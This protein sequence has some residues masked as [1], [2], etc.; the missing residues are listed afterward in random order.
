MYT[1]AKGKTYTLTIHAVIDLLDRADVVANQE[2]VLVG[3]DIVDEID[4]R[5]DAATL[6]GGE[7]GCVADHGELIKPQ[8]L[9]EM[10]WLLGLRVVEKLEKGR[11]S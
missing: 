4:E 2:P 3:E 1:K 9:E 6:E 8:L 10:E 5:F 7:V 11:H